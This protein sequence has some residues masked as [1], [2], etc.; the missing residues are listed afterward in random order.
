MSLFAKPRI[1]PVRPVIDVPEGFQVP[2]KTQWAFTPDLQNGVAQ[3]GISGTILT[4]TALGSHVTLHHSGDGAQFS[5]RQTDDYGTGLVFDFGDFTGDFFSLAFALPLEGVQTLGR[6]DLLRFV[7]RTHTREPFQAYARLNLCHGPNTEQ[8]VRMIDIGAG[9]S[10]A[11]FDIFYTGFE[12]KRAASA[13][14]D[15]IIND[16]AHKQITL[17]EVIIL[18]RARASL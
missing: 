4:G 11:E 10:F 14:I 18:R 3:G 1:A 2:P 5:I 8:V 15:L 12:P 6:Q 13:W 17:E 16:P 7:L 9:E